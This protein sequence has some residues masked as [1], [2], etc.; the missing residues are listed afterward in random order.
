[1][2]PVFFLSGQ[3]V[4]PGASDAQRR[5]ALAD[6]I[7]DRQNRWFARALV[8][9][10]WA[11]L[12]GQGFYEPIDDLGPDRQATAPQTLEMLA[13]AFVDHGYDLRWLMRSIM[14][15]TAYQRETRSR[16]DDATAAFAANCPQPLRAD[17]VFNALTAAL[18]LDE[19]QF[20]S[21][22]ARGAQ[23]GRRG[24]RAEFDRTF[25]F[26]PSAPRDEVAASIPQALL[27]MNSPL[28]SRAISS[29]VPGNILEKLLA[30][31]R[32]DAALATELYLR[33]LAREPKPQELS[34][35]LDYV[36]RAGDRPSAFEDILWAL[37]NTTEFTHRK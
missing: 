16:R 12:V 37:V 26:D 25:G 7:T 30:E 10:L 20:A 28:L 19:S 17:Q 31:N 11:E 8:N 34:A 33:C 22:G 36:R 5:Q 29:Q 35:C 15:T 4:A 32:D 23:L 1:M 27:M 3:R 14:A 6:W 21:P 13:S 9:R 18:A 24:P 2:E